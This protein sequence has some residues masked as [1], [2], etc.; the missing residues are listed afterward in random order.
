MNV[1]APALRIAV[2]PASEDST[3][4]ASA[5]EP[6]ADIP[7][8]AMEEAEAAIP[9]SH[10]R[11]VL[12]RRAKRPAVVLDGDR[13]RARTERSSASTPTAR[14]ETNARDSDEN[15]EEAEAEDASWQRRNLVYARV[16]RRADW[17]EQQHRAHLKAELQAI[18]A[19]ADIAPDERM[20]GAEIG[21]AN[22]LTRDLLYGT[23]I[24]QVLQRKIDRLV[25][26]HRGSLVPEAA[27]PLLE[28]LCAQ[29]DVAVQCIQHPSS[30]DGIFA[31][32]EQRVR[33][34]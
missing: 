23:I 19:A 10:T 31:S 26:M 11:A 33:R 12:P 30:G 4:A 8:P 32:D 25:M 16:D 15:A 29:H 27:F 7:V 13:K 6:H 9:S 24:E 28:W 1:S 17:S 5:R 21:A 2:K 14:D 18:E 34:Q 22:D 3:R 20:L